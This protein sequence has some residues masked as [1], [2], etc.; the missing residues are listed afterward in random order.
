MADTSAISGAGASLT[1]TNHNLPSQTDA[2][3]NLQIQDFIKLMISELQNQDPLNPM[4]NTQIMQEV[5]QMQSI[6]STTK[7]TQTLGQVLLGQNLAS[8][9]NLIGKGIVGL[10]DDGKQVVGTVDSL[11]IKNGQ[12][13]LNVSNNSGGDALESVL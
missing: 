3:S 1:S 11:S 6:T 5:S 10:T 12:G 13:Y 8:G 2:F 7:L 9:G 4:D